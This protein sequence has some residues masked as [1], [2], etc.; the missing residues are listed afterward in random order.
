MN[1]HFTEEETEKTLNIGKLLTFDN[2]NKCI[3]ADFN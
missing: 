1:Q 3:N 2:D